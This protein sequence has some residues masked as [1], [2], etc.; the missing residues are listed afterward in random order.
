MYLKFLKAIKDFFY[1]GPVKDVPKGHVH[2]PG[3]GGNGLDEPFMDC[4]YC[5]GQGHVPH[6]TYIDIMKE[7]E[8]ESDY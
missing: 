6:N 4:L 2:C 8:D 3:C 1:D 5:D 7:L